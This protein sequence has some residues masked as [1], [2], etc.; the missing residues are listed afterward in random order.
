MICKFASFFQKL[1]THR[2]R[3]NMKHC[4]QSFCQGLV[5]YKHYLFESS[6]A[7]QANSFVIKYDLRTGNVVR[8]YEFPDRND[9]AEGITIM[10]NKVVCV[11]W[12]TQKIYYFDLDLNLIRIK[13]YPFSECWGLS[14][15]SKSLI[16]TNG[17]NQTLFICP[18]TFAVTNA[19]TVKYNMLN[20]ICYHKGFI[21]AN[22]WKTN[23]IIKICAST[24]NVVSE[25]VHI[26]ETYSNKEFCL[27]GIAYSGI[28]NSF[29]ITGKCWKWFTNSYF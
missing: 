15:N 11:M 21:Y 23:K 3:D 29:I 6:G 20:A 10:K 4:E 25:I 1:M 7:Y 17:T 2:Q 16:M 14:S 27:N 28:K 26:G 5:K 8:K 22:I 19:I 18:K 12:K 13:P 9:F 24:G